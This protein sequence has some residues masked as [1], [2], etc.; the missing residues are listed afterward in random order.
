MPVAGFSTFGELFGINVN[1]ALTAIVF[2]D[3]SEKPLRATFIETFPIPYAGFVEYFVRGPLN[4]LTLLNRIREGILG[5]VVERLDASA[6]LSGKVE[7]ALEQASS[8]NAIVAD[9]R[10]VIMS[11]AESTAQAADT[12]TLSQQFAGL[13]QD[14]NGLRDI[15]K[16]IDTIAG[17]TNRDDRS[18]SRR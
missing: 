10:S 6:A 2:F 8:I 11:S 12:T 7:N 4:R 15:L 14:M 1:Q 9:I 18:G 5:R 3:T 13:T 17:Q 16:I